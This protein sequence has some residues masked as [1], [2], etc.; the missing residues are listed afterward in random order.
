MSGAIPVFPLYAFTAWTGTTLFLSYAFKCLIE[1][2]VS[3]V[4]LRREEMIIHE[5]FKLTQ[6]AVNS[7]SYV[8][9]IF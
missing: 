3:S 9:S 5:S 1:F 6:Q 2:Y 7:L 4:K 8:I